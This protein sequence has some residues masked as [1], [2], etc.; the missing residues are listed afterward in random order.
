MQVEERRDARRQPSRGGVPLASECAG[1][2]H[3]I[4]V[5]LGDRL[6]LGPGGA[7]GGITYADDDIAVWDCPDCSFTNADELTEP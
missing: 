6:V 2:G 1:C 3:D 5:H 7:R 4:D